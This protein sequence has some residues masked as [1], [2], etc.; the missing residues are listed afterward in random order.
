MVQRQRFQVD[1]PLVEDQQVLGKELDLHMQHFWDTNIWNT[2]LGSLIWEALLTQ[3]ANC[4]PHLPPTEDPAIWCNPTDWVHQNSHKC[5]WWKTAGH[6]HPAQFQIRQLCSCCSIGIQ[7]SAQMVRS[8]S[9]DQ[10]VLGN[11]PLFRSCCQL[12]ACK[13]RSGKFQVLI[14]LRCWHRP[15]MQS[16]CHRWC[17]ECHWLEDQE[18]HFLCHSLRESSG[19][20]HFAC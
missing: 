8:P 12:W 1:K 5:C 19:D 3:P 9:S 11:Q 13:N 17:Q 6:P 14:V 4:W 2:A 18:W 10:P 16:Y 7:S 20:L 15:Q